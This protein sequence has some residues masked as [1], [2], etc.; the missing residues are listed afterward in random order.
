MEIPLKS[1]YQIP[2]CPRQSHLKSSVES[3]VTLQLPDS[4]DPRNPSEPFGAISARKAQKA[5]PWPFLCRV[6]ARVF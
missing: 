4:I 3:P 2:F 6:G 1:H 5:R